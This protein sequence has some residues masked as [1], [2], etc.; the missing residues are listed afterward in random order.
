MIV[1]YEPIYALLNI[2][3]GIGAGRHSD[4]QVGGDALQR[5]DR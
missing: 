4:A 3:V 5:D 1:L 2:N